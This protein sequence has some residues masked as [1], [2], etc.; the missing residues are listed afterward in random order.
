MVLVMV[1]VLAFSG[2][3]FFFDHYRFPIMSV[4]VILSVATGLR[5]HTFST[6]VP[7]E[8]AAALPKEVRLSTTIRPD[9][10]RRRRR[11]RNPKADGPRA[12]CED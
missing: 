8:P 10:R 4:F 9:R 5:S 2:L 12:F 1:S 11:R 3:T 6:S 7:K